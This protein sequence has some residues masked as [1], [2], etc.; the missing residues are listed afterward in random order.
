MTQVS[1]SETEQTAQAEYDTA[2]YLF[3]IIEAQI[4]RADTKAGL[5]VAADSVFATALLLMSRGALLALFSGTAAWH[6]RLN[7]IAILTIFVLLLFSTLTSLV[8]ARPA[9]KV[10]DE[11]GTLFFF[12]RISQMEHK[13]FLESFSLQDASA[14]RQAILTEVHNTSQIATRKFRLIRY[15][16]DFLIGAVALWV[17]I[18]IVYGLTP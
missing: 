11:E 9:L 8:A 13:H 12:G 10:R 5:V 1:Q 15:S 7:A 2:A 6:E 4:T 18:Q 3:N 17:I 14:M 16:I